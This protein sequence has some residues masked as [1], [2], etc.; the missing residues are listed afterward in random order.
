MTPATPAGIPLPP[1][2]MSG[3]E[4]ALSAGGTR[5]RRSPSKAS[6][7][8]SNGVRIISFSLTSTINKVYLYLDRF[9]PRKRPLAPSLPH[10]QAVQPQSVP[11]LLVPK[12]P[13]PNLPSPAERKRP[14]A[15]N[16]RLFLIRRLTKYQ[17]RPPNAVSHLPQ[18]APQD[19]RRSRPQS[20][21]PS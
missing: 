18:G 12:P 20:L 8:Q 3:N 15:L 11:G 5:S 7:V 14:I 17:N 9:S 6:E 2:V 16:I 19:L 4:R 1:S 10:V 21:P 13:N